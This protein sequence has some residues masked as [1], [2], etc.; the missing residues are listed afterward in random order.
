MANTRRNP[1]SIF[2]EIPTAE[3][4]QVAEGIEYW[5]V[6]AF[7]RRTNK[8]QEEFRVSRLIEEQNK[9]DSRCSKIWVVCD[10]ANAHGAE[11]PNPA[12]KFYVWIGMTRADARKVKGFCQYNVTAPE[13]YHML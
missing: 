8:R 3:H 4:R 10:L 5:Y 6:K 1:D 7:T 9:R 12:G 2:L 11:L 13:L